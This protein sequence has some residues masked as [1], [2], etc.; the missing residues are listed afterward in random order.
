PTTI[1]ES[2]STETTTR[3]C[4]ERRQTVSPRPTSA[5]TYSR[6]RRARGAAPAPDGSVGARPSK[7][8][9][10][11][12]GAER[13]APPA[14]GRPWSRSCVVGGTGPTGP[15]G[16]PTHGEDDLGVLRVVLDLGAQPLD[17]HVDQPR[18][19]VVAVA[20]HLLE[21]HLAREHPPPPAGPAGDDGGM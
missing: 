11:G 10:D 21:Q 20:P 1:A 13:A 2:R 19:G 8:P 3:A 4:T 9:G 12:S 5:R 15:L 7:A 14:P 18:V 6:G 16:G 17:V